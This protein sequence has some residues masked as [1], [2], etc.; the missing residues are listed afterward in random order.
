MTSGATGSSYEPSAEI[1]D[2]LATWRRLASRGVTVSGIAAT[3]GISKSTLDKSIC[4]ARAH[5]HP[6]AILHPLAP[7]WQRQR[8]P[9]DG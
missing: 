4:R 5:G 9:P 1:A 2:R 7:R 3:L 6:D 8:R